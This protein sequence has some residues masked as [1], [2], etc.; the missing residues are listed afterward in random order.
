MIINLVVL[1]ILLV[2]LFILS[3]VFLRQARLEKN[4][5]P[6]DNPYRMSVILEELNE[7][8]TMYTGTW[9]NDKKLSTAQLKK[10]ETVQNITRKALH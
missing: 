2:L 3:L 8:F 1:I 4:S 5:A 10:L 7:Y 6:R 9:I